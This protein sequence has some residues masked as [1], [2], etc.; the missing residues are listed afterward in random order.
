MEINPFG[1]LFALVVVA[2]VILLC[3]F[4]VSE[5]LLSLGLFRKRNPKPRAFLI[6]LLFMIFSVSLFFYKC[7]PSK[8][9]P[10]RVE[11]KSL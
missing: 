4:L 8:T 7:S 3:A 6:I 10:V 11:T 1:V 2:L 9:D 5:L